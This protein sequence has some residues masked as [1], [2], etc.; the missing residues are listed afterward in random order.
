M[1]LI[2]TIDRRGFALGSLA[3]LLPA[4]AQ[5]APARSDAAKRLAAIEQASGGRLGAY[6]LDTRSGRGTG[7]RASERFAMCS[8]F[9][10]SLAALA[11]REAAAG[12]A[13]LDEPLAFTRADLLGNS[14]ETG[15]HVEEGRM[16][17]AALAEAAQRYS[18]NAA[19]N[20][21][22]RRFGGPAGL[23]RFWREIGDRQTRLDRF[24]PE[25]NR[26]APGE[27][28]D[29]TTPEAMARG[30]ARLLTGNVLAA[31]DRARLAGWMSETA[32]GMKR[33]RAALP[34]DWHGGD[35]TGTAGYAGMATKINDIAILYP[36]GGRAPLLVTAYYESPSTAEAVRPQDEAVLRQV[37]EVAVAWA[38]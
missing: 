32:T 14:P 20:L 5:A 9:K 11:L 23:T 34:A 26:V 30:I 2:P 3:L 21:L 10:L 6:I 36:P 22:L 18:D 15:K 1:T 29:T 33:I 13:A 27:V 37:G 16:T 4:C 7:W 19:A 31:A 28:R 25:L 12:R 8:T 17:I 35:K 38:S 24:E